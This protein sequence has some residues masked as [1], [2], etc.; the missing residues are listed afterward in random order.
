M[1]C[2]QLLVD[3]MH[4]HVSFSLF[5]LFHQSEVSIILFFGQQKTILLD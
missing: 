3:T 2:L 5:Q 4:F 1:L